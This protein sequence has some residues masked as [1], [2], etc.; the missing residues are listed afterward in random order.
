MGAGGR[1]SSLA[2]PVDVA[3]L[4]LLLARHPDD[5]QLARVPIDVTREPLTERGR[6]AR[7]G[8]HPGALLIELPGRDDTAVRPLLLQSAA[9]AEAKPAR[10][11]DD[12]RRVPLAQQSRDPRHELRRGKPSRW[13]RHR[14]VVLGDDDENFRVDVQSELD[15]CGRR[16]SLGFGSR[17]CGR[18]FRMNVCLNHT[19][20]ELPSPPAFFH[21]IY[22]MQRTAPAV[23]LAASC[24]RLS[25]TAQPSR[26]LRCNGFLDQ[27]LFSCWS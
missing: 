20:T 1:A 12:M 18:P 3:K 8:L 15:R 27:H 13:S 4:F 24:L 19:A 7:V 26:Q 25:S 17:G 10:L 5:G 23:T 14:V 2:L 21:D 6:V 11:I 9:Q 16:A 22:A